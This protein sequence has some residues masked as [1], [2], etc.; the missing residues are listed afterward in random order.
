MFCPRRRKMKG[1]KRLNSFFEDI[2]D[3]V[4]ID[5]DNEELSDVRS[6]ILD[7]LKRTVERINKR[8]LFKVS[9]IEPC[10]SMAEMTSLWKFP[11]SYKMQVHGSIEFD[12]LAVL[13]KQTH[14]VH[15][16]AKC[17]FC[18]EVLEPAMDTDRLSHEHGDL[19]AIKNYSC[20]PHTVDALFKKEIYFSITSECSCFSLVESPLNSHK[21][22]QNCRL[23]PTS[24]KYQNSCNRCG[25]KN[26]SGELQP[27]CWEEYES[28]SFLLLWTSFNQSLFSPDPEDLT[29]Q[30]P[31]QHLAVY[32]DFLPAI[33]VI[34]DKDL[35]H[36]CFLVPKQCQPCGFLSSTW[37]VSTCKDEVQAIAIMSE[38]HR[39]CFQLLKFLLQAQYSTSYHL[40][41]AVLNH[42]STCHD[43]SEDCP[44]CVFSVLRDL[45]RA[46]K[47]NH[48]KSFKLHA[49]LLPRQGYEIRMLAIYTE[50]ITLIMK[51]LSNFKS[52]KNLRKELGV[53]SPWSLNFPE[54]FFLL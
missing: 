46:Y 31:V 35:T 52:W 51:K 7:F 24:F 22:Y 45:R 18:M 5:Y 20:D 25:I 40:K 27:A 49:N 19:L 47:S 6:S 17:S 33:E 50:R 42:N 26:K 39:R 10:G 9:R 54:Q 28:C 8:G 53:M 48:L 11:S 36:V 34:D 29:K 3:N 16:T 37:R 21:G 44:S 23:E 4:A 13:D 30:T 1:N 32:V 2:L 38:K 43:S 41:T 15:R 12:F 14:H